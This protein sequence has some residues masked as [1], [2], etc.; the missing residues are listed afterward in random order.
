MEDTVKSFLEKCRV[1]KGE[2]HINTTKRLN[3]VFPEGSYYVPSKTYSSITPV[4]DGK[5]HNN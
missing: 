2:P 1:K 5:F 3:G 4:Y